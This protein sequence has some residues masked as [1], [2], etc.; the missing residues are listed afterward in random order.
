MN[1]YGAGELERVRD[2]SVRRLDGGGLPVLA[3]RRLAALFGGGAERFTSNLSVAGLAMSGP[4]GLRPVAQVMG[5]CVYHAPHATNHVCAM[6]AEKPGDAYRMPTTCESW[7][8]SRR[9]ALERLAAEARLCG[10][11][12]VVNVSVR[13]IQQHLSSS[14]DASIE[15]VATGTAVVGV[16]ATVIGGTVLTNLTMHG[17]WKLLQQGQAAVGL[18]AS[19][20]VL[21]CKPSPKTAQAEQ[22]HTRWFPAARQAREIPEFTKGLREAHRRAFQ[23]M[24]EQAAPLGATG[25]V[26]VII[27]REHHKVLPNDQRAPQRIVVVHALGTAIA[28]SALFGIAQPA[29]RGPLTFTPVRHLNQKGG[30][31]R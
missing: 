9:K 8:A 29:P 5:A 23:D 11:D 21:A 14:H 3:E 22:A 13:Q 6:A 16:P 30:A 17:Y 19:T 31:A 4:A 2:E 15:S 28:P 25:I 18:V 7:N 1:I 20:A 12:A 27:Q 24:R 10:A 26:G